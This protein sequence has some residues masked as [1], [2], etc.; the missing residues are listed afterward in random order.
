MAKAT[1]QIFNDGPN[2]DIR[3]TIDYG[4]GGKPDPIIAGMAKQIAEAFD[5]F[6]LAV[7]FDIPFGPKDF[8]RALRKKRR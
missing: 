4:D 7:K 8:K 5:E 1:I 3:V 6:C 2:D